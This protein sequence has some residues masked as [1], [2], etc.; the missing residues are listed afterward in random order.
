MNRHIVKAAISRGALVLLLC[1]IPISSLW[2]NTIEVVV[3]SKPIGILLFVISGFIVFLLIAV[4]LVKAG[5]KYEEKQRAFYQDFA[6]RHGFQFL[7][8]DAVG[9]ALELEDT[10][11]GKGRSDRD[12]SLKYIL[13]QSDQNSS[14]YLFYRE[15]AWYRRRS[16]DLCYTVCLFKINQ[17]FGLE[18]ELR[19]R[20]PGF[21]EKLTRWEQSTRSLL[22]NVLEEITILTYDEF[23]R[24]FVVYSDQEEAAKRL[25]SSE[26]MG[27]CLVHKNSFAVPGMVGVKVKHNKLMI[28][29][30]HQGFRKSFKDES[31][32]AEFLNLTRGLKGLL[33]KEISK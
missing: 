15:V 25:I 6:L 16:S 31:Q 28:Y 1:F 27:Y 14:L 19:K 20:M 2:A 13:T 10:D 30:Q 33:V 18:L 32:L 5:K 12:I 3:L 17:S 21:L 4:G 26:V 24:E 23:N 29:V 9:L 11:F 7:E 22:R 8:K